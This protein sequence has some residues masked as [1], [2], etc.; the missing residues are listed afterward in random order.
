MNIC[1]VNVG[2]NLGGVEKVAVELANSLHRRGDNI[3]LIDFSGENTFFYDID[4]GINTPNAIKAR[5]IRRKIIKRGLYF[6]HK[7]NKKSL[8]IL[9]L[10]KEQAEDLI[11]YLKQ[12]K[13][14]IVILCQDSLTALVPSL[15][16]EFPNIKIVAWQHN[17]YDVYTKQY[18][19]E[20]IDDY[21]SGIR[22]ADLVVCLT[23]ADLEKYKKLNVNSCYIYNPLTI[24]ETKISNLNNNIIVF[25]GRLK[26]EQKGLDYLINIA[27]ELEPGWK[28]LVA[29]DGADK[30]EFKNLI[31]TNKLED[32]IILKGSLR[33]NELIDFYSLGSIFISTSRW[34]GFGLV[35]TEAMASGLPVISFNN[36]GPKEILK[37][38][39]YG[40]LVEKYNIDDFILQLKELILDREKREFFQ[41]KSIE[42]SKD[43]ST[44]VILKEW[45]IKLKSL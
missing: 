32:K 45:A 33:G 5:K 7:I 16:E 22:Q 25:V 11:K 28:I 37:D 18:S 8:N 3:A 9:D 23:S 24:S 6:K 19:K 14:E 34:E 35:I 43:F 17:N 27:R 20:F 26:I 36:L 30:R 15:K 10:Y 12:S 42:R 40:I 29:G 13:H 44:Q 39:E 31:I 21:F 38:G 4:K 41:R 2:F 1:I